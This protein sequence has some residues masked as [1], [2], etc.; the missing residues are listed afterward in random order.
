MIYDLL[1]VGGGIAGLYT[2]YEYLKKHPT[3]TILILERNRNIGGRIDTFHNTHYRKGIEAGAGR[4]HKK[5]TLLMNLLKEL[6]LEKYAI[7]ISNFDT[8]YPIETKT[9]EPIDITLTK[10]VVQHSRTT[11]IETLKNTIFIDYA[12]T[13]LTPNEIKTLIG[14][15][16]YSSELTDMNAYDTIQLIKDHF[17]PNNQFYSLRGG[18]TQVIQ[19]LYDDL[20][21]KHVKILTHRRVINT[22]YITNQKHSDKN[23]FETICENIQQKYYSKI[24]VYATTK[25]TIQK[26]PI[27]KPLIPILEKIHTLPLCRIYAKFS[28]PFNQWFQGLPKIT[29]N[30]NLRIVIPIDETTIMISYTDNHYARFWKDLNDKKGIEAVNKELQRLVHQTLNINIRE[31]EHTEIFYWEHAVAYF[32]KGFD[33]KKDTKKILCPNKN[34]PLFICGENF[35]EKNNQWIEGSLDT[36]KYILQKIG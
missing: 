35:S 3:H 26:I 34:I 15:F 6:N 25:E 30:N 32:G 21:R 23:Y 27:F 33:S 7:P 29:T 22:D 14:S 24:C 13:I 5:Q 18:L 16:G 17:N 12:K 31:P 2:A 4:F 8:Y 20:K 10:K 11:H 36:S 28:P 1:I 9:P 19:T